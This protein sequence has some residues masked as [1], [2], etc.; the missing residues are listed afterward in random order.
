MSS[1][2]LFT[3][4]PFLNQSLGGYEWATLIEEPAPPSNWGVL[5]IDLLLNSESRRTP[6]ECNVRYFLSHVSRT[7][8]APP[9]V[10]WEGSV[11]Y[12]KCVLH[13]ATKSRPSG[14]TPWLGFMSAM[15]HLPSTEQP[16]AICL[17]YKTSRNV[18]L[19]RTGKK[20]STSKIKITDISLFVQLKTGVCLFTIF[21][22]KIAQIFCSTDLHYACVE[23]VNVMN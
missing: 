3:R 5:K 15:L 8:E 11:S 4:L 17:L 12:Q 16:K 14:F 10:N 1:C 20:R 13:I 22:S 23:S 19:K 18:N 6:L 7:W 9:S 21:N 2:M